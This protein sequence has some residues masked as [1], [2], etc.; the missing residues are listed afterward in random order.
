MKLHFYF[1]RKFLFSFMG[2]FIVFL[3]LNLLVDLV[4]QLRKFDVDAVGFGTIVLMT[5]LNAPKGIYQIL[6]LVMILSTVVLFLGLSR[7]SE[8][9]VTRAAGRSA[10][11]SLL[12]PVIMGFLIGVIAVSTLNPIVSFASHQYETMADRLHNDGV[13]TLSISE[14]GLWLRQ[15]TKD[16]QTVIHARFANGDATVLYEV[17]MTS[18]APDGGPQSRIMAR[19]ARLLDGAWHMKRVKIWPL[20][21]ATNPEQAAQTH[22]TYELPSTL[23]QDNIRDGFGS[24]NRISVWDLPAYIAQLEQAGFSARRHKMWL[25]RELA[26]PLFLVAM[27]LAAAAFTMR[28]TRFG[29]TGLAVL[30]SVLLG[31]VF[32]Y[33]RNFAQILG[34]NGQ[35]GYLLAAWAPPAAAVML[36]LALLLHMEDG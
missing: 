15:G 19:S 22:P 31:F 24:P 35:I 34:E 16:G 7:S 12:S 11:V 20:G 9:V 6:P 30:A 14:E 26:Q 5:A 36:A 29:R 18:Y 32:Y 28:H 25:H 27:V 10:L 2:L 33:V 8:L 13:S 3:T 4:E 23:T 1:A 17:T 21:D